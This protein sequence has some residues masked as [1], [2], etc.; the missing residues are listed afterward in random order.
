MGLPYSAGRILIGG[1]KQQGFLS[2]ESRCDLIE[3]ARDGSADNRFAQ[4]ANAL[5]LLDADESFSEV[6]EFLLLDDGYDPHVGS[7][8]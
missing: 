7:T 8:V 3:L 6:A 5:M 4:R 2:E 1:M